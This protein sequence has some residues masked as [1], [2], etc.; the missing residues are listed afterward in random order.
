VN[1]PKV[2]Y[3]K[4]DY[5][6]TLYDFF[7]MGISLLGLHWAPESLSWIY[8]HVLGTQ[9]GESGVGDMAQLETEAG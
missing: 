7:G 4:P 5:K 1:S 6:G 9:F 3:P 8:S 2:R